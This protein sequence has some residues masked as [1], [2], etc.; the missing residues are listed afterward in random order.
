MVEL[1]VRQFGDPLK[2][3]PLGD[4]I[5]E[6]YLIFGRDSVEGAGFG[7]ILLVYMIVGNK[8]VKKSKKI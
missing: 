5:N 6:E 7:I 2:G 4:L 8:F 3:F 1:N